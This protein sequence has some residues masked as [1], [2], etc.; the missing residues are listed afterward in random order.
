[1]LVLR[2]MEEPL[3][4]SSSL[5]A[6]VVISMAIST[7]REISRIEDTTLLLRIVMRSMMM[8]GVLLLLKRRGVDDLAF[9]LF[10]TKASCHHLA[11]KRSKETKAE[12]STR[13]KTNRVTG[14]P[15]KIQYS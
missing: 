11:L 10:D 12:Q 3:E 1:M 5:E 2:M 9:I 15:L 4:F 13:G 7:Q 14:S 8:M 6:F